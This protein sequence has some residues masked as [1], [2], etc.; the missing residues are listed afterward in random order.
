MS[1]YN[2][3]TFS[4]SIRRLIDKFGFTIILSREDEEVGRL[5]AAFEATKRQDAGLAPSTNVD[6]QK[7]MYVSYSPSI[8]PKVGDY[9]TLQ[10]GDVLYVTVVEEYKPAGTTIA[11]KVSMS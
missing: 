7:V 5:T 6:T 2:Y 1:T 11:Y 4:A 3:D 8:T 10:D 9:V